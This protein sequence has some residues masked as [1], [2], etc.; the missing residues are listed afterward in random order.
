MSTAELE[1]KDIIER[2]IIADTELEEVLQKNERIKL[3]ILGSSAFII[4]KYL[5]RTTR[6]IDVY[7]TADKRIK[8]ILDNNAINDRCMPIINICEGFEKRVNKVNL[9]LKHIEVF[10]LGDYDLLIS[11]IGTG[12]PKDLDDI[13]QSGLI[14]KIDFNKLES[15][16]KE[17]LATAVNEQRLWSDVNYL[18]SI[19]K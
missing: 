16:I 15:I 1:L 8:E 18:K 11:K 3:T 14:E 13:V 19:K 2:I 9:N 10:V 12:R 5:N 7:I 17:E 4:K 6:D